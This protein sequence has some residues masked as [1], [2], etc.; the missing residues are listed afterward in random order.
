M[1]QALP[2]P[3]VALQQLVEDGLVASDT[4]AMTVD[5][6]LR[7]TAKGGETLDAAISA[8]VWRCRINAGKSEPSA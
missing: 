2:P 4:A 8:G 7:L 5:S 1:V 3:F 6:V